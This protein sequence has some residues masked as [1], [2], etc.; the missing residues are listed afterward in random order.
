MPIVFAAIP[1]GLGVPGARLVF[2]V[3][4]IVVLILMLVQ[5]PI[6]KR[7]GLRLGVV[8]SDEAVE[9]ELESAP[10]DGMQAQVLGIEVPKGSGLVG[11]FVNEIGLPDGAVV[12]LIVRGGTAIAPDANTRIRA[13]DQVLIV[14][15]EEAREATEQRIRD[16]VDRGRLARW[17]E[18]R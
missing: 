16:V 14:T 9:L 7:V 4:L 11:T 3:T 17:F 1:L 18:Q 12:S 6:L 5:M 8:K 13:G 10:L 2:D 15:T